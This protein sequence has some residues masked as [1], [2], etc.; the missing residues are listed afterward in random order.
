MNLEDLKKPFPADDIEW[1]VQSSGIKDNKPWAMVLAYVTNRAIMDRLDEVCGAER[2]QNEF[3]N[4]PGGGVICGISVHI[5]VDYSEGG[6]TY[7]EWV[8]KWDG[9]DKTQI[10]A[11]KGGLSGAMKRAG[12]QWGIGRYLYRL[13]AAWAVFTPSGKYSAK[14]ENKYYKWGPP[15]LPSWALPDGAEPVVH[16]KTDAPEKKENPKHTLTAEQANRLKTL[17]KGKGVSKEEMIRAM[18]Y[19][20]GETGVTEDIARAIIKEWPRHYEEWVAWEIEQAKGA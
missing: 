11:V 12:V 14:I 5:D 18:A 16:Q 2:W 10:E 17:R 7:R 20:G 6:E 19:W 4:G 9:A 15:A 1:R 3:T 8:T 13:D